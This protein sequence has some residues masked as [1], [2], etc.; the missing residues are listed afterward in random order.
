[1]DIYAYNA[2]F[3]RCFSLPYT[4][5][6]L[7]AAANYIF[8][9]ERPSHTSKS[10]H[11]SCVVYFSRVASIHLENTDRFV[12]ATRN[13]FFSRWR[14]I[15]VYHGFHVIHMYVNWR[16]QL[17]DIIGVQTETSIFKIRG[18]RMLSYP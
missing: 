14:V 6:H 1:M 10:M 16:F 2:K 12:I 9:V 18:K 3:F 11:A 15:H 17:T 7:I 8:V 4:K 13:K 5:I